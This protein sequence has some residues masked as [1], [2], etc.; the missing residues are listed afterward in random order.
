M[1][2]PD[3]TRAM[4]QGAASAFVDVLRARRPDLAWKPIGIDG[5]DDAP[6][7]RRKPGREMP[8]GDHHRTLR[9]GPAA[10]ADEHGSERAA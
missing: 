5:P 3:V 6:G 4:R 2:G 1:T 7:T 10:A 8:G 9:G